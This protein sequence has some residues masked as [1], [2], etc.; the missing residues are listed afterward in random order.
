MLNSMKWCRPCLFIQLREQK[1]SLSIL[2]GIKIQSLK[3][4]LLFHS[5][6]VNVNSRM[7]EHIY[8]SMEDNRLF[9]LNNNTNYTVFIFVVSV[10]VYWN[11]QSLM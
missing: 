9:H 7:C 2:L 11:I 5:F 1:E 10:R 6:K 4:V 3:L 8:K